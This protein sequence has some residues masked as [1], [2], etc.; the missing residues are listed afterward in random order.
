MSSNSSTSD[1]EAGGFNLKLYDTSFCCLADLGMGLGLLLIGVFWAG[2][3]LSMSMRRKSWES[4]S[5]L[6]A[7]YG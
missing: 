4:S 2:A 7:S 5:A 6:L 3:S 1:S